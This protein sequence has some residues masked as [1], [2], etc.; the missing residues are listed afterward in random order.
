MQGWT[1][2]SKPTGMTPWSWPGQRPRQGSPGIFLIE[3][4]F[5]IA[6][7]GVGPGKI[8]HCWTISWGNPGKCTRTVQPCLHVYVL[9]VP[10][11]MDVLHAWVLQEFHLTRSLAGYGAL[12]FI[13]PV[14]VQAEAQT[15]R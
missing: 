9:H 14:A 4:V 5:F 6:L 3:L 10:I 13:D 8:H 2:P 12:H 11:H 7:L 1:A 15:C